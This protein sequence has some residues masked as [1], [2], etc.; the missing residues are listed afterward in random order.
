MARQRSPLS[1]AILDL[2]RRFGYRKT[3][4]ILDFLAGWALA[5]RANDWQP[6]DAEAYA[7]Y[8]KLSRAKG[9]RDQQTWRDLFPDE[10]TPNERIIRARAEYERL[11]AEQQRE[12]SRA[13][14]AAFIAT[15]PA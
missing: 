2:G 11:I 6:I 8:W 7:A 3:V 14:I 15:M 10:P 1:T 12:P 5:V 13:E 4:W 9:F